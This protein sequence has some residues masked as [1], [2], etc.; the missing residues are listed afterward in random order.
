M[1]NSFDGKR[2]I[3]VF[4]SPNS[5]KE[6]KQTSDKRRRRNDSRDAR[7]GRA[8]RRLNRIHTNAHSVE[9]LEKRLA[10]RSCL[11]GRVTL[12]AQAYPA[13]TCT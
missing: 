4:T 7:A 5:E 9:L 3:V 12:A 11:F 2:E 1:A 8:I 13:N 6:L 10:L